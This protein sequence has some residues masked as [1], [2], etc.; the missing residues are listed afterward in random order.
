MS[1]SPSHAEQAELA[2]EVD[3][4]PHLGEIQGRSP[5]Q[6]VLRRLRRD[7]ITMIALVA[8]VIIVLLAVVAP[9]LKSLG[10]LDLNGHDELVQGIGS[11]P[12]GPLGGMSARHPL[13]VQPGTGIDLLS[14]ILSGMTTSL[15]VAVSSTVVAIVVGTVMGLLSGFAGGKVD[16]VI[17]R[18]IDLVLS[19]PQTLMLLSLQAVLVSAIASAIGMADTASTPK[20]LFMIVVL[21]FFGWPYFARIVRGQVMSLRQR[22]FVEAARSL[23]A[24]PW[25]IYVHELLPHLW[26]PILVYTTMLLPQFVAQE[27]ALGFLGVGVPP[28]AI[29]LGTLLNDSVQ[30]ALPDP[31]YFF[32]PGFAVFLMVLSFN[33]LGDGVRDALDPKADRQ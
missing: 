12:T 22:E 30:Y 25:R 7:R 21:G 33:L 32:F 3:H 2:V 16:W 5:W 15:I 1:T 20:L 27:A 17:S 11:M 18:F 10:V 24:R 23:G 28:P 31:A 14:L 8:T 29:S 13:G 26:A 9:I 4:E 19:F 6:L